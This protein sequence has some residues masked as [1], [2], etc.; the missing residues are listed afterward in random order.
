MV[1]AHRKMPP[2]CLYGITLVS[3]GDKNF[4]FQQK[5]GQDKNGDTY[6]GCKEEL[7]F[8]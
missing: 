2:K 6:F 7:F 4:L 3:F 8:H 1:V 5:L